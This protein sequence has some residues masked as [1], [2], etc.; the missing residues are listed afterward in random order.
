MTESLLNQ[1]K[2]NY[3]SF[4]K[5]HK[6][7]A[8]YIL[9][10]YDKAA[11]MTAA[12]LG[13]ATDISESTVVRFATHL[14][15]DGY[16]EF[17]SALLENI[18]NKLTAA[19]RMDVT[20][21]QLKE[22]DI[23]QKVMTGDMSMIKQTLDNIST[24]SF[25][26]SVKAINSAETI[27]ILGS[28]SCAP[29]AHFI[30]F[31]Y[32]LVYDNVKVVDS[33]NPTAMFEQIFKINKNDVCIA[34]SFPRYSNQTV[35]TLQYAHESGAKIIVITDNERS[36]IAQFADYTLTAKSNMASFIDS[37]VAPLSLIN[38]LI[39]ASTLEKRD[40]VAENFENLEKIWEKYDVYAKSD[41]DEMQR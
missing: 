41:D 20:A 13:A 18:K 15:F 19:E 28:R 26:K 38:A 4:S 39:V 17:Q 36:P 29:L 1:I 31:Y 40:E 25:D 12:K 8:D 7:I 3:N 6:K 30:G 22:E 37:L 16:P 14:G 21:D 5:S 34:I 10:N 24:D 23:L 27:Y 11:F 32:N 33:G 2:K 35:N 9:N